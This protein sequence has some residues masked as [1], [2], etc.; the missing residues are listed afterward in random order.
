MI[1]PSMT[2]RRGAH[3][4]DFDMTGHE[5]EMHAVFVMVFTIVALMISN[6]I[7]G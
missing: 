1:Q 6:V 5:F 7:K 3:I 4:R 2:R